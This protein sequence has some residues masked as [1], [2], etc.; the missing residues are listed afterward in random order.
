MKKTLKLLAFTLLLIMATISCSD[1]ES[2]ED[3]KI[4]KDMKIL[5]VFEDEPAIVS[6]EGFLNLTS[7]SL[8]TEFSPLIP[9]GG[10]P[11]QYRQHGLAVY[12]SGNV[13]N[14]R[15]GSGIRTRIRYASFYLF[16]L[17]SIKINDQKTQEHMDIEDE[18]M[19]RTCGSVLDFDEMQ[20]TDPEQYKRFMDY[21]ELLQNLLNQ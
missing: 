10:L 1:K 20:K 18:Y 21:E 4:C 6:G 19:K 2:D 17:T 7:T 15:S 5:K 3:D 9:I 8:Q 14:C 12:I 16:E 11:E 13:T